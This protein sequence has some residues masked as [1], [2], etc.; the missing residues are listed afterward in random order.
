MS[1]AQRYWDSQAVKRLK[2][3][4]KKRE[5]FQKCYSF[6]NPYLEKNFH[7][8]DFGSGAGLLAFELSDKVESIH[9]IDFSEA[10]V[11]IAKAQK[12]PGVHNN[13]I[14]EIGDIEKTG[15]K[16]KT[17]D[18]ALLFNLL[19]CIENSELV[20]REAR[21]IV[22]TNGIIITS[23]YCFLSIRS[24]SGFFRFL[25]ALFSKLLNLTPA[26][27]IMSFNQLRHKLENSGMVIIAEKKLSIR[28]ISVL[29]TVL[30][31]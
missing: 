23:S 3:Q 12:R 5:L 27:N 22:K 19:H 17:K 18:V 24:L 8:A 1:N 31:T 25:S 7:I 13:I 2:Y 20:L 29:F 30:K 16:E 10:M 14:F 28:G 21:R 26:L 6:I 4:S 15:I 11:S 9:A